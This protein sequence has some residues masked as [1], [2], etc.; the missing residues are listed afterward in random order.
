MLLVSTEHVAYKLGRN[1]Q[2]SNSAVLAG[3]GSLHPQQPWAVDKH[4][5]KS[6]SSSSSSS[7]QAFFCILSRA[8]WRDAGTSLQAALGCREGIEELGDREREGRGQL[9]QEGQEDG[10]LVASLWWWGY[11]ERQP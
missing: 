1:R 2:S 6:R 7:W 10:E 11:S 5:C 9:A 3:E 8:T 4:T